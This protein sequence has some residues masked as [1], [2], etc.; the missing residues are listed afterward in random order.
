MQLN[1]GLREY[2]ER[3][4]NLFAHLGSYAV[5]LS[6][7]EARSANMEP[8]SHPRPSLTRNTPYIITIGRWDTHRTVG[9]TPDGQN[10]VMLKME[11]IQGGSCPASFP[12][13]LT[14]Q[15]FGGWGGDHS[16]I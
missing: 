9:G 1:F 5:L 13:M 6:L 11:L 12:R 14:K 4:A 7:L 2:G 10:T 8:G 16:L 3:L 15:G